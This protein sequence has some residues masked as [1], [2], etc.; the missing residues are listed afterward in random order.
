[1]GCTQLCLR[2]QGVARKKERKQYNH[3]QSSQLGRL[4]YMQ[5]TCAPVHN[6]FFLT[7]RTHLCF[8]PRMGHATSSLRCDHVCAQSYTCIFSAGGD[9]VFSGEAATQGHKVRHIFMYGTAR[10]ARLK[11][12]VRR[13][14]I[15]TA[16]TCTS[17]SPGQ[18][19]GL[20]LHLWVS[21]LC[22]CHSHNIHCHSCLNRL[23]VPESPILSCFIR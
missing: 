15:G 3:T 12:A 22:V 17:F 9:D 19:N 11:T 7:R 8:S 23:S 21:L 1:M 14:R 2:F 10:R 4:P 5:C 16:K 6:C 20:L 13:P 18:D